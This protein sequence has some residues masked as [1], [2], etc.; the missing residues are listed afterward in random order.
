MRYLVLCLL[1]VACA[2][3]EDNWWEIQE[4]AAVKTNATLM[5]AAAKA[6]DINREFDVRVQRNL[7]S[8][9]E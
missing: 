1:L 7:D 3:E 4:A 2:T 9:E 5:V 8:K 6:K